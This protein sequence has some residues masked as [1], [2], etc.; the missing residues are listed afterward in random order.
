MSYTVEKQDWVR[1]LGETVRALLSL[2][3]ECRA[4]GDTVS[5]ALEA[6]DSGDTV[7]VF[8]LHTTEVPIRNNTP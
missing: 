1:M 2:Y 6:R 4:R 7:I 3:R 5:L 8:S